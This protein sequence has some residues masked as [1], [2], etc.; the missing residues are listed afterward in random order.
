M[1]PSIISPGI[2]RVSQLTSPLTLLEDEE[3][4]SIPTVYKV[5]VGGLSSSHSWCVHCEPWAFLSSATSNSMFSLWV[6]TQPSDRNPQI[7]PDWRSSRPFGTLT[8]D[9]PL[10]VAF[11]HPGG[12]TRHQPPHHADLPL[13]AHLYVLSSAWGPL[14]YRRPALVSSPLVFCALFTS[15]LSLEGSACSAQPLP[16]ALGRLDKAMQTGG[17]PLPPP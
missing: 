17:T 3:W 15:H 5:G 10:H 8:G 14:A 4:L 2:P 6:W 7:I 9:S 13:E 12:S 16:P 11:C 1:T